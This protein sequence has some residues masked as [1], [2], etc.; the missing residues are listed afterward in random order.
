MHVASRAIHDRKAGMRFRL[1]NFSV[2]SVR[3]KIITLEIRDCD[4]PGKHSRIK[5]APLAAYD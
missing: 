1:L 2:M 5:G 3:W 4:A